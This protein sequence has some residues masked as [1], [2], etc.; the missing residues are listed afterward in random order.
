MEYDE[1]TWVPIKREYSIFTWNCG[2]Y[3]NKIYHSENTIPELEIQYGFSKFGGF[4]KIVGLISIDYT[5]NFYFASICTTE[6]PIT[7]IPMY[8]TP[9]AEDE[10][11]GE[12]GTHKLDIPLVNPLKNVWRNST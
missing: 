7:G 12:E 9:Y 3:K 6:D 5:F 2:R 1:G 11:I 10:V 8:F 4:C